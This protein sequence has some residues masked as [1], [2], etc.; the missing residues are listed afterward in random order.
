[1]RKFIRV[2]VIAAAAILLLLGG[3]NFFLH[4]WLNRQLPRILNGDPGREYDIRYTD[5]SVHWFTRT[6]SLK[7]ITILPFHAGAT[8]DSAGIYA[9]IDGFVIR[10]FALGSLIWKKE[11][12]TRL[13]Q[14]A[15]P[16]ITLRLKPGELNRDSLSSNI[17]LKTLLDRIR[18]NNIRVTDGFLTITDQQKKE[19]VLSAGPLDVRLRDVVADSATVASPFPFR[20]GS[21]EISGD[22]VVFHPDTLY[23]M[24]VP[25]LQ[26]KNHMLELDS[27]QL[28]SRYSRDVFQQKI[29]YQQDWYRLSAP[30]IRLRDISWGVARKQIYV[31]ARSLFLEN[32]VF[33]SYRDKRVPFRSVEKPMPGTALKRLPFLLTID[34]LSVSGSRI[35]YEEHP[36]APRSSG[37]VVFDR[38]SCHA[39]NISNDSVWLLKHPVCDVQ[40]QSLLLGATPLKAHFRF[41][42]SD[43]GDAFEVGATLGSLPMATLNRTLKPLADITASGRVQ[44]LDL[45]IRGND[46]SA[47]S[48]MRLL[49]DSLTLDIFEKEGHK[50]NRL[51]SAVANLFIRKHNKPEDDQPQ[52]AT[53]RF[54]RYRD[55]SFFNYLWNSIKKGALTTLLNAQHSRFKRE[56]LQDFM[57][58]S[59][60]KKKAS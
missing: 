16:R 3:G 1:M 14:A 38:L 52:T 7:D 35:T 51:L 33:L 19:P 32:T 4:S 22:S 27:L 23:I 10:G 30:R 26:L 13:L 2:A 54:T 5:F 55:R 31:H 44:S 53:F 41:R 46:I 17:F 60:E 24:R 29:G 56:Q 43:P 37:A 42:L 20:Y 15:H 57:Q 6:L 34:S 28:A 9:K 11:I 36:D 40:A 50:T 8:A 58:R 48:N 39:A 12:H 45:T 21:V 59:E 49:Y 18:V 47:G 25:H